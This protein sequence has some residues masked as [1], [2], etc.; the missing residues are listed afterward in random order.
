MNGPLLVTG[1]SGQFGQRVLHHLLET[2][3][4][5][6][7]LVIAATRTPEKLGRWEYRGVVTRYADF[8][9]EGSLPGAFRGAARVL[10]ISTDA[11]LP[12]RRQEQHQRAI[13]VAEQAG[14]RHVIYTSMP[15]PVR[16]LVLF[17]P[18]HAATESLLAN[19][20]L[21][22]W[23][24]LRNHWYF[25]NLFV[26]LPEVLARGGIWFSAAGDGRLADISRDD[27]ALAAAC[28]LASY[29]P[30]KTTYTLSGQEA[31]TTGEQ[32]KLIGAAIGRRI[33]VVPVASDDL[34][35][36]M[37]GAGIPKHAASLLASFD[38]NAASGHMGKVTAD[39]PKLTGL[40][41]LSFARWLVANRTALT[42]SV[43]VA[44][45]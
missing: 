25:E 8:D 21:P 20:T 27:L 39:Y 13:S 34:V 17:A 38:V 7:G 35:R 3:R 40:R 23:T 11:D 2:F 33:Q 29:S 19:S 45:R 30:G 43:E 15:A 4:I 37:V 28:E 14:V 32:A 31:L 22:G 12:G 41:P 24:V 26:A 36:A 6:P 1:A 18:D 10:L 9:D 42:S 16:S 5:P 44:N